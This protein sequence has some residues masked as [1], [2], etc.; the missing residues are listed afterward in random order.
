M[1][2]DDIKQLIAWGILTPRA[3]F[4]SETERAGLTF[5]MQASPLLTEA[6]ERHKLE[7]YIHLREQDGAR[8]PVW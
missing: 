2:F 1:T 8:R 3:F 5:D 7:L 4:E 6:L